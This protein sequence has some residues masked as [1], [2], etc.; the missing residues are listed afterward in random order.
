MRQSERDEL[1]RLAG[2]ADKLITLNLEGHIPWRQEVMDAF[3]V[4]ANPKSLLDLLAENHRMR[5]LLSRASFVLSGL[6]YPSAVESDIESFLSE[7]S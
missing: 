6:D 4:A 2:N 5:E 7:P 3:N 1:K